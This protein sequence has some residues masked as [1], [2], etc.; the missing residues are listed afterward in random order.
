MEDSMHACMACSVCC[1][2]T[3]ESR[4]RSLNLSQIF[5]L[6]S[7]GFGTI[8][9]TLLVMW[10]DHCASQVKFSVVLLCRELSVFGIRCLLWKMLCGKRNILLA[11]L[12]GECVASVRFGSFGIILN[13]QILVILDYCLLL[14]A[15]SS[16]LGKLVSGRVCM[17]LSCMHSDLHR[18]C[19][20]FGLG[21]FAFFC[22]FAS[23]RCSRSEKNRL[24]FSRQGFFSDRMLV[25]LLDLFL[26]FSW[27]WREIM[28][29]RLES[30]WIVS[31]ET[32]KAGRNLFSC[33]W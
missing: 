16:F 7:N 26:V 29:C 5:Q 33:H 2:A 4:W 21:C 32:R 27:A 25:I 9:C 13:A 28:L 1:A 24:Q 15:F 31:L 6:T 12:A 30:S 22:W 8:G 10:I 19:F 20:S 17:S 23:S 18:L 14:V 3:S 11:S